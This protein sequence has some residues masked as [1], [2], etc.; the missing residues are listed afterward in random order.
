MAVDLILHFVLFM[1]PT[2][3]LINIAAPTF[4][5]YVVVHATWTSTKSGNIM[6]YELVW[7]KIVNNAVLLLTIIHS[8]L[9]FRC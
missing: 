6:L 9:L 8:T 2:T 4:A 7:L 5:I 1:S 3:L